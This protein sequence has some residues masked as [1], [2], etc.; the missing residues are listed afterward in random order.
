MLFW[1]LFYRRIG[2][3]RSLIEALILPQQSCCRLV[4]D[5]QNGLDPMPELD[6]VPMGEKGEEEVGGVAAPEVDAETSF[7]ARTKKV[8]GDLKVLCWARLLNPVKILWQR[9]CNQF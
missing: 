4:G 9:D 8:L 2:H 3:I 7:T 1:I 6:A 5:G